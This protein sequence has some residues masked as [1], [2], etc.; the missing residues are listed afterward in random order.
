MEEAN[1]ANNYVV[2]KKT[3][4]FSLKKTLLTFSFIGSLPIFIFFLTLV[5]LTFKYQSD[6][7][8][9]RQL[10]KPQFQAVPE[11]IP[12]SSINLELHDG[13][14]DALDEFFASYNS[15]LEGH[16]KTIVTEADMHNIDYRLLPA[17]AMKESTLCKKIIKDS[18][19]C[20]GFGIY[21]NKV[22]KF[23]DFESAIKTVTSTLSKKYIQLGYE[24]PE[25]IMTKY[26]PSSNGSW[27]EVV[28]LIMARLQDSL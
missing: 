23:E 8:V 12:Q 19:N 9:S 4:E 20:W 10:H 22:T 24:S 14:V 6:G 11:D 1:S 2:G 17:I 7:F 16:A 3:K 25:E 13:R 21:G 27:A 15:P 5:S 18:Y 26:T 28:N